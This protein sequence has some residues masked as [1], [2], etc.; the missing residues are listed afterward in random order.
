MIKALWI[1]LF[2]AGLA[3]CGSSGG[4][5]TSSASSVVSSSP[6]SESRSSASQSSVSSM[7]VTD[8]C[9]QGRHIV[10][11]F[12]DWQ[13]EVADVQFP[14]LTHINYS[15][16]LPNAD[17]GLQPLG[18]AGENR[19]MALVS[20]AR[21]A[22][23]KVGIALGGWNDGD[24]SAFVALA[25][26]AQ[27]R[28]RFVQAVT[29]FV[30]EYE[31]DGVDM[32]WE[33]PSSDEEAA[34]YLLLMQQM[35]ESLDALPGEHF[36]TAAVVGAGDWAGR[37]ILPEVFEIVDFLNL[38]AY[39]NTSEP[40]HSSFNYAI[41]ALDYWSAR[42]LTREKTVLGVPFYGRPSYTAYRQY[43]ANSLD[44]AC[45]SEVGNDFY[46]GIISVREK[47]QLVQSRTC[48]IMMWELTQ[49]TTDDTSL[50]RAMWEVVEGEPASY[51]CPES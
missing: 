48:G 11:Y 15:F 10:G 45:V 3:A 2:A 12:P 29:D 47:A 43:V 33:Y 38:M 37:Y 46:N 24:D 23:V 16:L 42:G 18:V 21:P 32:D 51:F 7:P 28:T 27:T 13:G 1:T 22:G 44:N 26:E 35:R 6:S 34:N 41:A 25:Q 30:V 49:D 40:H 17:G 20:M 5:G 50:L 9:P 31:L 19:L 39:D 4:S 8:E 14:Y 36:L